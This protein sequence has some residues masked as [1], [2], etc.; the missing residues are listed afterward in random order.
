M[1]KKWDYETCKKIALTCDTRKE[2]KNKYYQVHYKIYRKKWY[3]LLEHMEREASKA[4][5]CVYA[6]FFKNYF[7]YIG[8]TCNIEKRNSNHKISGP[9]FEHSI[10]CGE[11]VPEPVILVD[12]IHYLDAVKIESELINILSKNNKIHLLNRERGGG[13]GSWESKIDDL[14]TCVENSK[15]C[16][17][18]GE[19]RHNY[20]SSYKLYES[21]E[22]AKYEVSKYLPTKKRVIV[23]FTSDG[24]FYK[25]F[26]GKKEAEKEC[27]TR[28]VSDSCREHY[29]TNGYCF[30]FY[31]DWEKNGKPFLIKS[32]EEKKDIGH[33]N[34]TLK[35]N[36]RYKK[37]GNPQ[38]GRKKSLE[39]IIKKSKPLVM[40]DLKGNVVDVVYGCSY[41]AKK[42]NIPGIIKS[43]CKC[44][45]NILKSAYGYRW[46]DLKYYNDRFG[47]NLNIISICQK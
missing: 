6:Y 15:K 33:K 34:T 42:Y 32:Q 41:A 39:C 5:R 8:I 45:N 36:E 1:I 12:Y 23:S 22:K 25:E 46:F 44:K 10:K 9:V 3:E 43:V 29:Y 16:K 4:E 21:N 11:N 38:K 13:L 35:R 20:Y 31:S 37:Q 47:T 26:Y 2:L 7:I 40:T 30:Y 24:K 17:T 27:D 18:V 19:F 14:K 28:Y